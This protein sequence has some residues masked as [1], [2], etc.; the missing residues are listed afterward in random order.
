MTKKVKAPMTK[1]E[2]AK[3]KLKKK[4]AQK[5]VDSRVEA[6]NSMN[7]G[8]TASIP[9]AEKN[10]PLTEWEKEYGSKL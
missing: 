7:G 6:H 8:P 5:A 9:G 3:Q 4:L 2:L 1:K 10:E